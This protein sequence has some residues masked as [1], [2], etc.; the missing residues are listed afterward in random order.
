MKRGETV[1]KAQ[2]D[3]ATL[4][5]QGE[6]TQVGL[7]GESSRLHACRVHWCMLPQ[8]VS[9]VMWDAFGFFTHNRIGPEWLGYEAG[10]IYIP[11]WVLTQVLGGQN[12][13]S[14]RDVIRH[15]YGHAVAHYYPSLI[16]RSSRFT[17]TFGG[18]YDEASHRVPLGPEEAI[19]PYA[20]TNPAEDF[21]E[22]FMLYLKHGTRRPAKFK[23]V[24]IQRRWQ[25]VADLTERIAAGAARW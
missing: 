1:S 10:H 9:R 6:L 5:V 7:W 8:V 16:R 20:A 22:T 14:L 23:S 4:D 3:A 19:S 11:Q 25:F 2:L 13:G 18:R 15:E 12:R 24:A 17:Q 21:A